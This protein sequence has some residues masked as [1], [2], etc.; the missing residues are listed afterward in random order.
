M[1]QKK[2]EV[3]I[4]RLLG[5]QNN[6]P[7]EIEILRIGSSLNLI[8]TKRLPLRLDDLVEHFK[9]SYLYFTDFNFLRDGS[10]ILG[11]IYL[12]YNAIRRIVILTNF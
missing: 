10:I 7:A 6:L 1:T 4:A 8:S 5:P 11:C 3:V 2:D 12:V 9:P